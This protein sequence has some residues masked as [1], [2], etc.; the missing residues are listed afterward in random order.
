MGITTTYVTIINPQN[1]KQG[2]ELEFLVDSGA[3]YS[4][5]PKET[6][7]KIGIKPHRKQVFT[8][9]DGS[10]VE[11]EMGDCIYELEGI[12]GAAPIVFGKKG[13]AT[14]LGIFTLE[15]LGLALDPFKRKLKPMKLIL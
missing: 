14:L 10:K 6:L 4:V 7:E 2:Q 1:P 12:R 3:V 11:R 5:A 15:A 9:T 13:D 8:L